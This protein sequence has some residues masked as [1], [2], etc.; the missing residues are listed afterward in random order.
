MKYP[1]DIILYQQSIFKLKSLF[2]S[3]N[4]IIF[5]KLLQYFIYEILIFMLNNS[6]ELKV[7]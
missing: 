1:F 6:H 5:L 7:Y 3:K 2:L 4:Q